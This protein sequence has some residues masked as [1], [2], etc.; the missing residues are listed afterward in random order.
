MYSWL[1]LLIYCNGE[2]IRNLDRKKFCLFPVE[3]IYHNQ[4]RHPVDLSDLQNLLVRFS[5][6]YHHILFACTEPKS[7]WQFWL[8]VRARVEEALEDRL[9]VGHC[10]GRVVQAGVHRLL[11]RGQRVH[12]AVVD[13]GHDRGAAG[14]EDLGAAIGE[15]ADLTVATDGDDAAVGSDGHGLGSTLPGA[16]ED[17][18]AEDHASG[19]PA[20]RPGR[21]TRGR[22]VQGEAGGRGPG[23]RDQGA[24]GQ[25]VGVRVGHGR[26][27]G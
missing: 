18:A 9:K 27:D 24:T 2:T 21:R 11:G 19:A 12:V 5:E 7:A 1:I 10:E 16:G 22:P 15:A 23:G 20:A 14:M 4:A 8:L 6:S 17:V 3:Y 25:V 26:D 13:A